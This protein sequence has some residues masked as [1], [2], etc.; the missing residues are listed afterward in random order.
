MLIF[1][2]TNIF[3][4]DFQMT[5]T[6]FELLKNFIAKGGN[7]LCV[8]EIII[9]E[10]KNKYREQ[11]TELYQKA[12]S[13]I[14]E[15]NKHTSTDMCLISEEQIATEI[16]NYNKLWDIWP[17]EYGNGLPETY[18]NI[19][20]KEVVQR[21]LERKKP[22]KSDGKD[23]YR[24]YLIWVTF[25][26][27]VSH[28]SMED[29]CFVTL[30]T[31]DFSDVENKDSLHQHLKNDLKDKGIDLSRVH[32][33]TSLKA[34]IEKE[35]KPKLRVIEEHEGLIATFMADKSGFMEPLE[36][37]LI[38]EILGLELAAYD[39]AIMEEG[40]N[41]SVN[42][43]EEV[44]EIEI[45]DISEISTNEYLFSIHAQALCDISFNIFKSDSYSMDDFRQIFIVDSEWNKHYSLAETLME[46][47]ISFEVIFD[48]DKKQIISINIQNVDDAYADCPLCP[49]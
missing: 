32:Y 36:E 12:N 6:S 29:A 46:L 25:L 4:T 49:Y 41:H 14:R 26:D 44:S 48:L 24:D 37:A 20:H 11:I 35:V 47:E 42:Q 39:I 5:S 38:Q 10:V 28:Y 16:E 2:D 3:C 43:V 17:F 18:P 34:F 30:N 9:D 13:G 19:S 8:P 33:F 31:R 45:E 27:V 15:L 21:A 23:G 1:L 22:F 40:E 7:W